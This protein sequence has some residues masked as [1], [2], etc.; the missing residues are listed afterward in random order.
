MSSRRRFANLAV[1]TT[2]A[3]FTAACTPEKIASFLSE[4]IVAPK[5]RVVDV[6]PRVIDAVSGRVIIKYDMAPALL[7]V[8]FHFTG[9]ERTNVGALYPVHVHPGLACDGVDV[10]VAHDLGAPASSI[11]VGDLNIPSVSIDDTPLPIEH[12]TT[13]Y[14]LDVHA[15]N[16]PRGL[17]LAC[18][19]F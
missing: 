19:V 10:P 3:T 16:D 9:V 5:V 4:G 13:G 15:P 11:K 7:T 1:L 12:L 14:Y 17:Q 8:T 2:L 6:V 18:A